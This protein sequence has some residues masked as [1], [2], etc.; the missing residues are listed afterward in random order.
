L[1]AS[2]S[3][4][5]FERLATDY[6]TGRDKKKIGSI[7]HIEDFERDLAA[8]EESNGGPKAD[9]CRYPLQETAV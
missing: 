4:S 9:L 3:T 6:N 8:I 1:C 2:E 5:E 7:D